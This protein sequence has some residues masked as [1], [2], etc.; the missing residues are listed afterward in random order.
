MTDLIKSFALYEQAIES[1]WLRFLPDPAVSVERLE[2][3]AGVRAA[4]R[5]AFLQQLNE[6]VDGNHH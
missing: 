2:E 4:C 5:T 3:L 1:Y 6:I